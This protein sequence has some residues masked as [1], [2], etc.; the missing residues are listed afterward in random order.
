[1][2]VAPFQDLPFDDPNKTNLAGSA[3]IKQKVPAPL[4]R[5]RRPRRGHQVTY[6]PKGEAKAHVYAIDCGMKSPRCRNV[7]TA[8]S[9]DDDDPH[10]FRSAV[11][12]CS[13]V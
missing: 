3:S 10:C 5:L 4:R 7:R 1:M 11:H 9:H 12:E 2:L 8:V 13:A 6:E